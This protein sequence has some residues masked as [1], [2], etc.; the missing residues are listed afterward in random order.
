[1]SDFPA[2]V[3]PSSIV[4]SNGAIV[5]VAISDPKRPERD[6]TL[7]IPACKRDE[8]AAII[9]AR[10]KADSEQAK[11]SVPFEQRVYP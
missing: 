11:Q 10:Q 6:E 9:T 1:V 2:N 4:E 3:Y 8:A 5:A 7:I